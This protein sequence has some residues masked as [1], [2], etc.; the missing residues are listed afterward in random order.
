M[1]VKESILITGFFGWNNLKLILK[2][3]VK[4]VSNKDSLF[5]LKRFQT[6]VAFFI[7]I[8]GAVYVLYNFVDTVEKFII[9]A[10]PLLLIGGYNIIQTQKEKTELLNNEK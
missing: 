9:W 2:E 7:F 1:K 6:I 8:Q 10:T 4:M 5:S 3:L